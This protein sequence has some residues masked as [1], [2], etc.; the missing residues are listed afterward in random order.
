MARTKRKK[1]QNQQQPP[2]QHAIVPSNQVATTNQNQ[3]QP[4]AQP[5]IVPTKPVTNQARQENRAIHLAVLE[6]QLR[7]DDLVVK[8]LMGCR[9][10][11]AEEIETT[12]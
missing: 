2:A 3:Q 4:P 6:E 9:T 7:L 5:A 8:D 12:R 10:S 11:L 1:N